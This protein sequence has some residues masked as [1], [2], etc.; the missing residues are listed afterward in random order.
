MEK[1]N[2]IQRIVSRETGVSIE[3]LRGQ[4]RKA[5]VITARHLSMY[6]SRW[7]S[8]QSLM[9]IAAEHGKDTHGTVINAC[10][11]VD[12]QRK[13]NKS[14]AEVYELILKQIKQIK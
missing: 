4:S 13:T 9:R 14:Y 8:E 5:S 3:S 7:H 6:F 2:F 12:N 10:F 11:S 1:I